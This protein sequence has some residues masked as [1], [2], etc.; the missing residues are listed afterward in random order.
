MCG[1]RGGTSEPGQVTSSAL[2]CTRTSH[3]QAPSLL[4]MVVPNATIPGCV[5]TRSSEPGPA[6]TNN[7]SPSRAQLTGTRIGRAP[8]DS[9]RYPSFASWSKVRQLSGLRRGGVAR[10]TAV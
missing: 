9:A 7:E 6:R 3:R 2:P 5:V 8:R 10:S 1:N 4:G